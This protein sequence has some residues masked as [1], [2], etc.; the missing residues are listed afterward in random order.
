MGHLFHD[1]KSQAA[2]TE[3]F[4][5]Q[6]AQRFV[7]QCVLCMF[8]EDRGML[9]NRQFYLALEDCREKG[10]STYDVLGRLFSAMNTPGETPGGRFKGTPYFNGGLFSEIPQIDLSSS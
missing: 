9:P 3:Q 5:A 8:A 6:Q 1:L 10:D 2:R 7:L 4:S